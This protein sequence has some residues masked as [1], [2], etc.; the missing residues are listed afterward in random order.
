MPK[1]EGQQCG[2]CRLYEHVPDEARYGKQWNFNTGYCGY[3]SPHA[4]RSGKPQTAFDNWCMHW[5]PMEQEMDV[6]K[7]IIAE[8][9]RRMA[10]K[11][12]D[13]TELTEDEAVSVEVSE[14]KTDD[15][16]FVDRSYR[17]RGESNSTTEATEEQPPYPLPGDF[18]DR[19][20]EE[21]I[22]KL[23]ETLHYY[24]VRFQNM[25]MATVPRDPDDRRKQMVD[26]HITEA[27]VMRAVRKLKEAKQRY[28][29][30]D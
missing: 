10:A 9:N 17:P 2:N 8:G 26:Y 16:I 7:A 14:P 12:R 1:P 21:D 30:Q 23:A 6:S 24:E 13:D 20:T 27:K 18:M 19:V 5:K 28:S 25:R 15:D 4:S 22:E 29:Y 11:E 3:K